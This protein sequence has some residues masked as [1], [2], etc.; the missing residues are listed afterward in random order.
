MLLRNLTDLEFL[1]NEKLL[2]WVI[3]RERTKIHGNINRMLI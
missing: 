3:P 1:V 2:S